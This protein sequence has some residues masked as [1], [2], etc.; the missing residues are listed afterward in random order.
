MKQ[1]IL[2]LGAAAALGFA[3]AAQAVV[4]FGPGTLHNSGLPTFWDESASPFTNTPYNQGEKLHLAAGGIGSVLFTPYYNVQNGTDT[5]LSIANTDN[6]NGKAVKVR[7]RTASNSDDVLDFTLL[8]S[9]GDMWTA[10]LTRVDDG[11]PVIQT[12]DTSC[13]LPTNGPRRMLPT[14]LGGEGGVELKSGNLPAYLDDAAHYALSSEGYIEVLNMADIPA[15]YFNIVTSA[16]E[17]S[18][19]YGTI[20]HT[21]GKPECNAN[22]FINLTSTDI[23]PNADAQN[24]G[25]FPPTGGLFGSWIVINQDVVSAYSGNMTAVRVEDANGNPAYG[26]IIFSPQRNTK[27]DL[28]T[29][30]AAIGSKIDAQYDATNSGGP[31]VNSAGGI[32]A[33]PLLSTSAPIQA[34]V[35]WDLPDMSTPLITAISSP[36]DQVMA[37]EL[38]HHQIY[39][40]YLNDATGSVPMWTDWVVSQPT[41]R[42]H[43]A[44]DYS[45]SAAAARLVW[46]MTMGSSPT[47]YADGSADNITFGDEVTA[48]VTD[49]VYNGLFLKDMG[50]L[51]PFACLDTGIVL[52]GSLDREE[53]SVEGDVGDPSDFSPGKPDPKVARCGE[54]FVVQF[55]GSSV[56]NAM[57]TSEKF[58]D[59]AGKAGFAQITFAER[60]LPVVGYS[61]TSIRNSETGKNYGATYGHRWNDVRLP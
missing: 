21:G 16:Y 20:K 7:L 27:I 4:A 48:V 14:G 47:D 59:T 53:G 50:D 61:A 44:V 19:L 49:N 18:A 35:W 42:Y 17:A 40:E 56:F 15:Q 39:N 60:S 24:Y 3:G 22:Q 43:A 54:V 13:M 36:Q 32:T 26:N 30:G 46:N 23:I 38:A 31:D 5:L 8:L 28:A 45:A 2:A 29:L 52:T 10:T 12:T 6:Q 57:V 11:A 51:G 33:D 58:G 55:A 1:S 37:L 34:P 9:P 41:R 25:L